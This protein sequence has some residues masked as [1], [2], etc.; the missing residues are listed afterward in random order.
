MP[1]DINRDFPI[2]ITSVLTYVMCT[3]ISRINQ[4][5]MPPLHSNMIYLFVRHSGLW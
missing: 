2:K 3:M 5:S 4:T 1:T